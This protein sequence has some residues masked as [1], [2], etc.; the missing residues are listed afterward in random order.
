MRMID[1]IMSLS[2][3]RTM[4]AATTVMNGCHV[5]YYYTEKSSSDYFYA[6]LSTTL[7]DLREQIHTKV[8]SMLERNW[9]ERDV[10]HPNSASIMI[11]ASK[12]EVFSLKMHKEVDGFHNRHTW[13]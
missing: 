12:K 6:T 10:I 11:S 4:S 2:S 5:T 13:I 1:Y 9:G 3:P 7:G 8:K